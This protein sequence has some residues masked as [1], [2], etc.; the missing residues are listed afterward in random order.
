[1]IYNPDERLKIPCIG[2]PFICIGK[3]SLDNIFGV[4]N[5]GF[6]IEDNPNPNLLLE[7][8]ASML[9]EDKQNILLEQQKIKIWQKA[10]R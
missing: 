7:S 3:F 6:I 5:R 9:W 2:I 4:T 8:G 1:M 10:R